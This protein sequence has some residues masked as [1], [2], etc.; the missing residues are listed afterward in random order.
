MKPPDAIGLVP[1]QSSRTKAKKPRA[2]KGETWRGHC[3]SPSL[4]MEQ[5]KRE[6]VAA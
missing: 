5:V 2:K 4:L 3:E 1:P 6:L